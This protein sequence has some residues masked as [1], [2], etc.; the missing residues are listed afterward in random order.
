MPG[1]PFTLQ[2]GIST[3]AFLS[4]ESNLYWGALED[5]TYR[6]CLMF[7]K[8]FAVKGDVSGILLV[9]VLI[10]IYYLRSY[11]VGGRVALISR[12]LTFESEIDDHA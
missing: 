5:A 10:M 4:F 3:A 12:H 1:V 6:I 8:E 7:F 2:K 9:V 11:V